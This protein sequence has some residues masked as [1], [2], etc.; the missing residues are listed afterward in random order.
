MCDK[1]RKSSEESVV[2]WSRFEIP[3]LRNE[4]SFPD[5]RLGPLLC[6]RQPTNG[7]R[8]IEREAD[9]PTRLGYIGYGFHAG[10]DE[11]TG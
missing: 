9:R 11:E 5:F 7:R 3:D 8:D 6:G 10:E 1:C 4:N 2:Y